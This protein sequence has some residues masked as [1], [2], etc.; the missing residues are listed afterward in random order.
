MQNSKVVDG[1][2]MI[3]DFRVGMGCQT[4]AFQFV[5]HSLVESIPVLRLRRLPLLLPFP[6]CVSPSI[7]INVRLMF[8]PLIIIFCHN[9]LVHITASVQTS[10]K[11]VAIPFF[12]FSA[13][14]K[15][16]LPS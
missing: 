16:N 13:P 10:P 3:M 14:N 8:M 7:A 2:P 12:L 5:I 4:F 1:N 15:Y 6:P 11:R 9:I